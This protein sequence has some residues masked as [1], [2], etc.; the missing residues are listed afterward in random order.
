MHSTDSNSPTSSEPAASAGGTTGASTQANAP[1]QSATAAAGEKWRELRTSLRN[2]LQIT[3]QVNRGEPVYVLYDPVSFQAHRLN[4]LDYQVV[5][6]LSADRTLEQCFALCV[7]KGLLTTDNEAE[8]RSFVMRLDSLSLLSTSQQDSNALFKRFSDRITAE[9]RSKILGF[10]FLTIPL[11]NPDRFLSRSIGYF[12]FLFTRIAFLAWAVMLVLS[13]GLVWTR[14]DAF[15]EPLNSILATKNLLFMSI[16]FVALKVWH[17]LGHGYACKHFGGRV[18]EMG[19]KL[20]VG[21]PLAYVD[22]TSAW[23]FPKRLH[24]IIVMLG[25]MYFE[26]LVAIPAAFVWAFYPESFLGS[27]AYQL[28][29]MAG[30]ATI[31]FNANPLMKYD[32]YFILSDMIGMPNLR[33]KSTAELQG[34]FKTKVLGLPNRSRA[35]PSEKWILLS[36]GIASTIYSVTLLISISFMIALRFQAI[37]LLLAG[38]QIGSMLFKQLQKLTNYLLKSAETEPVRPRAKQVAWAI[39]IGGPLLLLLLPV[40]S[41]FQVPGVVSARQSTVVRARAPGVVDELL[42]TIDRPVASGQ[43]L[44]R[45]TDVDTEAQV[46]ADRLT[47]EASTRAA[48]FVSRDDPTEAAKLQL[49]A[50]QA[51]RQLA[52]SEQQQEKLLIRAPHDGRLV[53]MLPD[54]GKGVFVKAGDP[55]ARI[56]AG[57]TVIRAY[58]DEDQIANGRIEAGRQ[59][60]IRFADSSGSH[61][62]GTIITVSPAR[63]GNFE[64]LAITTNGQ[65]SIP[66]D[67]ET[68]E[69]QKPMF[70]MR[71]RVADLASN[72]AFQD[73]RATVLLGRKYEPLGFWMARYTRNFVNSIFAS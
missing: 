37:G 63:A 9:R 70:L 64:D 56:V 19:C 14:W 50:F 23:S 26:S 62:Q 46:E 38:F 29:F 66:V 17:E 6:C 2:D 68:G 8:F 27:C 1:T 57:E 51:Q 47:A 32:G 44:A 10:L 59:V 43:V 20:I 61:H 55:I 42:G 58:V 18:P 40:P 12:A 31:F 30:V 33:A 53:H 34:I 54:Y 60:A 13:A 7:E 35:M 69:T 71:V 48:I 15:I 39:A 3:R 16:A 72:D 4:L 49:N 67:P 65:G 24:R 25:G 28:I 36:Y 41:G 21:M 73:L 52:Q 11:T 5:S 45:I 22:A